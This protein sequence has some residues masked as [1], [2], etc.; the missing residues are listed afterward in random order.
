[1]RA[2]AQVLGI[3]E[4]GTWAIGTI[5]VVVFGVS[6][7][8]NANR[9]IQRTRLYQAAFWL[10]DNLEVGG[11]LLTQIR[12]RVV[13]WPGRGDH[14]AAETKHAGQ[15]GI[16]LQQFLQ[17]IGAVL[18]L[19]KRFVEAFLSSLRVMFPKSRMFL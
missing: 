4:N 19:R 10:F 12:D 13:C 17:I 18:I 8:F 7:E 9:A 11:K 14:I 1:M 2:H 3:E 5:E 16:T 6:L 15:R